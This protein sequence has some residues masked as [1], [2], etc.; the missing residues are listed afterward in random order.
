MDRRSLRPNVPP[1][2][3]AVYARSSY[4]QTR[5]DLAR[6][7]TLWQEVVAVLV[8]LPHTDVII[9]SY[10]AR[11][12]SG[13]AARLSLGWVS[14]LRQRH[15]GCPILVAG[16]FNAPHTT[17]GYVTSSARGKCVYDTFVDAQFVLLNDVSVPTRRCER[18]RDTP[19]SPDLAWWLGSG[20]VT[21]MCEP[22]CWGSDH[23]P[24]HL[25]LSPGRR[26][27]LRRLCRVVDW[28][29]YRSASATMVSGPLPDPCPRLR[30][31]L[32]AAT[33]T[34]WVEE[35]RPAPDLQLCRLWAAR[36]QAELA[37][38]RNPTSIDARLKLQ[39]LTAAA[40]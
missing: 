24:V 36:R 4:P 31:A 21:W 33:R 8:R 5:I 25:G 23:H 14:H 3:V 34:T 22:D 26:D 17:W 38:V 29:V 13:R 32:D 28:D 30:A 6:W 16:D 9:V 40:R 12:Y 39:C 18:P 27:R 20:A 10:Y 2:K 35:S 37:S 11:P 7:C 1:G 19:R 15:P